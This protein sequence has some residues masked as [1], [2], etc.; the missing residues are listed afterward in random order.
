[1]NNNEVD[2]AVDQLAE[3]FDAAEQDLVGRLT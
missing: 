1:L 3:Y 2:Q